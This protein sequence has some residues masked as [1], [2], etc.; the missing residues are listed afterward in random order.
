MGLDVLERRLREIT[1]WL[2]LSKASSFKHVGLPAIKMI[3][4]HAQ[5][6]SEG[7]VRLALYVG[8]RLAIV[9]SA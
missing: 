2:E 9:L 5:G 3:S 1:W 6:T 4:D 7:P 8:R